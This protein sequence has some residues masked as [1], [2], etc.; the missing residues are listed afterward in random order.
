PKGE[1]QLLARGET[2]RV[3]SPGVTEAFPYARDRLLRE[4]AAPVD[5]H[6]LVRVAEG[7]KTGGHT[8][9]LRATE[10]EGHPVPI[11]VP[12]GRGNHLRRLDGQLSDARERVRD[13]ASLRLQLRFVAEML[14]RA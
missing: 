4:K 1:P 12:G 9:A 5:V 13:D 6:D 2:P 7:V 8:P 11:P 14:Q 3:R 10:R